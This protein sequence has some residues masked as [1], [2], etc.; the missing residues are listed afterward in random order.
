MQFPSLAGIKSGLIEFIRN[1]Q[2]RGF[3]F[4]VVVMAIISIAFFYPDNFEGNDL[5]QHDMLQG[6]ANGQEIKEYAEETGN[7][8]FWTNAL[9]SGMPTFQIA[10]T[11]PSNS[12]FAWFTKIYGLGLPSPSNLLFMMMVGFMILMMTMRVRWEYGLIGAIAWGF[13]TYFI[14]IIGAGHIW[15]FVTLAYIPPTIGGI[16]LAYRGRYLSGAAMAAFFAMM[17]LNANHIQMTYYFCFVI[18]ALVIAYFIKALRQKKMRRWGIATAALAAAALLA[19]GANLPS[20]Y[21]TSKYAKETQRE[22]SEVDNNDPATADKVKRDY[23]T[24][25]SYGRSETFTL[26][27]PNVKGGASVRPE[28]GQLAPMALA[29]LDG[30]EKYSDNPYV[31]LYLNYSTQYFGEPEMTNGPV[32]VGVIIFALFVMGCVTVRGPVK[33]GLLAVLIVTV[34]L[35]WGRN[36]QWLTDLFI[37]IVPMYSKFR[38]VESILVVAEFIIPLIAVL[39]LFRL[40]NPAPALR[41]NLPSRPAD[42]TTCR[43]KFLKEKG[44]IAIAAGFGI[45]G[46]IC[47]LG[48]MNPSLFGAGFNEE[49]E[50]RNSAMIAQQLHYQGYPDEVVQLVSIDN[51]DV[52]HAVEDLHLSLVRKD[53][54]RSLIYL[55]LGLGAVGI[56]RFNLLKSDRYSKL[57][58]VGAIG[59]LVFVDLY[60]VNKRYLSHESFFVPELTASEAVIEPTPADRD[61]LSDT[62]PN[63][64]V[65][66]FDR[67]GE[68]TPSYFHKTIGG[69]HAAKLGRYNDLINSGVIA[70]EPVLNMLNARYI[71]SGKQVYEN[72]MALGNAW[73]VDN[74]KYV[75]NANQELD[76]LRTLSPATEAVADKSMEK[77]LGDATP[78]DIADTIVETSYAPDR[79]TYK[80]NASTPRVA[81][82]SEIYF[83]WGWEATIDGKPAE[84][85]RVNYVL[86]AIVVPAGTHEI[87][88]TFD[89]KSVHTTVTV[90]TV[91]VILIY[92]L[93]ITAIACSMARGGKERE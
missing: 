29:G 62:D 78:G 84:I 30:A 22:Q 68:A 35:A 42:K 39:G 37:D 19:V 53:C 61:I 83:P 5:R 44:D 23:I 49:S 14:I 69:Y 11:Y 55:L 51:P 21:H 40:Y 41:P 1:R 2:T 38:T 43:G 28:A 86:R 75:D 16:V 3:L 4:S 57:V 64:R 36:C 10:P 93:V 87:T 46:I 47:L 91:S 48:A 9:F 76:A 90:A 32:Y 79:L 15:K 34:M 12:L 13:S 59:L 89:P 73:F 17:Q 82:F 27:I 52:A 74:I 66:D 25:Y 85:A 67:F 45:V 65:A 18:A 50:L 88:M 72:D 70:S 80:S 71:V 8:S 20:L 63:Y 58:S 60:S 56:W 26:F 6:M 81:V 31:N 92:L 7:Q 33:W 54:V 77:I 24:Q